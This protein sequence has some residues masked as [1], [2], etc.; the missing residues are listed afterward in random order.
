MSDTALP[1]PDNLDPHEDIN[2]LK[3]RIII[4][5]LKEIKAEPDPAKKEQIAKEVYRILHPNEVHRD[6]KGQHQ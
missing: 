5:S 6:S 3:A 1:Y 4:E 2:V